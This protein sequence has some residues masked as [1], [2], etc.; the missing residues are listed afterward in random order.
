MRAGKGMH[1]VL[2]INQLRQCE[3]SDVLRFI[4]ASVFTSSYLTLFG[5]PFQ[6]NLARL[7]VFNIHNPTFSFLRFF[8]RTFFFVFFLIHTS[9]SFTIARRECCSPFDANLVAFHVLFR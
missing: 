6:A 7:D 2:F 3:Y 1:H 9:N 8:L 5:V 4:Y